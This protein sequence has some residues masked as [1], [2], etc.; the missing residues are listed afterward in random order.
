MELAR[1]LELEV[2]PEDITGFLQFHDKTWTDEQLFLMDKQSGF[3]K[4][5]LL[6]VKML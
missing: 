6:L 3:W 2:E 4:W 1:E 5:N